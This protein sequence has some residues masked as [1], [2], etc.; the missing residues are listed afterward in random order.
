MSYFSAESEAKAKENAPK[1]YWQDGITRRVTIVPEFRPSKKDPM[2]QVRWLIIRDVDNFQE[3]QNPEFSLQTALH[4]LP[5]G[6]KYEDM[7][8]KV[9]PT[10]VET[11]AA[12]F[13]RFTFSVE[14]TGEYVE[15]VDAGSAF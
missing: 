10:F 11:D 8:L 4:E 7:V 15:K 2:K 1:G 12:G 5:D 6:A 3:R 13:D 9:T 14:A